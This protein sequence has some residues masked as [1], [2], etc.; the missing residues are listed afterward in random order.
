M[1]EYNINDEKKGLDPEKDDKYQFSD[2]VR[3][4][5]KLGFFVLVMRV[6]YELVLIDLFD[7]TT[8]KILTGIALILPFVIFGIP[9]ITYIVSLFKQKNGEP[10]F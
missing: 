2:A 8:A 10:G 1:S 9:V 3:H 7:K 6:T 5:L 4:I